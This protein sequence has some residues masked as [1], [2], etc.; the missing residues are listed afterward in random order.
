MKCI[1]FILILWTLYQIKWKCHCGCLLLSSAQTLLIE[2]WLWKTGWSEICEKVMTITLS[3]VTMSDPDHC[4]LLF[5]GTAQVKLSTEI[6]P[7]WELL[8][9]MLLPSSPKQGRKQ[10][11]RMSTWTRDD[12]IQWCI[13][14]SKCDTPGKTK[15]K[16][17]SS[18]GNGVWVSYE[19]GFPAI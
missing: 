4:H 14:D 9:L 19:V 2:H 11:P 12:L 3:L 15:R 5:M 13:C 16:A 18:T 17:N 6:W 7:K 8:S 1:L 10:M